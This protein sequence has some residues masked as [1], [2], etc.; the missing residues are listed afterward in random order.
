MRAR[1]QPLRPISELRLK[2]L[3]LGLRLV[4]VAR[5]IRIS[6]PKLSR[7]ERDEVRVAAEDVSKLTTFYEQASVIAE[8]AMGRSA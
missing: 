4:D 8:I 1:T 6:V 7:I 5:A 2:R 3:Q